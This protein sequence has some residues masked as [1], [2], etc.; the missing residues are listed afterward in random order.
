MYFFNFSSFYFAKFI[1][2]TDFLISFGGNGQN[3]HFLSFV[4]KGD[5]KIS[6]CTVI[7]S[8]SVGAFSFA[9]YFH[10]L[11]QFTNSSVFGLFFVATALSC[12]LYL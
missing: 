2:F 1:L 12:P 3:S 4:L 7:K 9:S 8:F 10:L 11:K 5:F 6:N